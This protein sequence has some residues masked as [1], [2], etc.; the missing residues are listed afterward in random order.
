MDLV[1]S[2]CLAQWVLL[3]LHLSQAETSLR[4]DMSPLAC[5]GSFAGTFS[6]SLHVHIISS[7]HIALVICNLVICPGLSTSSESLLAISSSSHDGAS[8]FKPTELYARIDAPPPTPMP[9]L[10]PVLM[11]SAF[12]CV[13]EKSL[14][15]ADLAIS[16]CL[17]KTSS[18]SYHLLPLGS[19]FQKFPAW[20]VK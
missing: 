12:C 19:S 4:K 7:P 3:A 11:P 2:Q 20:C 13:T 15:T 8:E 5:R 10:S 16:P 14:Y 18:G 17:L 6:L 9:S 1:S